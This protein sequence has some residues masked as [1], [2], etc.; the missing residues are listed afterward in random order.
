[1]RVSAANADCPLVSAVIP[2]RG[3]PGFLV[4]A[5]RS[6]LRQTWPKMEVV[7]VVD[8]PD[9]TT[10]AQLQMLRDARIRTVFLD[11]ACGGS[12][13]RNAGVR[14][15]RGEWIAFLD[16]D[17]EWMP[18]KIERQLRAAAAMPE[19]FP[20]VSCRVIAQSATVSRVLPP[21]TWKGPQPVADYL[22][23]REGFRDPGGLMQSSTLLAPRELLLAVPFQAGLAMHQDWDWTIRVA[24]HK[25]VGLR[26]L[27]QP[28]VLWRVE[29]N[30]SS[31]GRSPD[32]RAS[33]AW[34]L[35]MRPLISPRAFSWF[36]AIQCA[37][38]VQASRAGLSARIALLWLYLAQGRPE[39]R[40]FLLFF[41][42]GCIPTGLRKW[43]SS[44]LKKMVLASEPA[45]GLQLAFVRTSD[46]AA[47][48]RTSR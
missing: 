43:L 24:G 19:W 8:G 46:A 10:E 23:C 32:W 34:I 40:S 28:L 17:D 4:G 9:P 14:V 26:M 42:F 1:M 16:D 27:A 31:V 13:A 11:Q 22:F 25:G 44:M 5:I 18:E 39:M 47:L 37:W 3:R 20:V 2:T 7:V 21:R 41:F 15:A 29:E 35:R 6:V 38:R 33:L 45:P 36:I 48:R 12:E 30:R